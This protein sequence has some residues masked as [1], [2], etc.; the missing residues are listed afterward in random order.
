VSLTWISPQGNAD[1]RSPFYCSA[2]FCL[3]LV[4]LAAGAPARGEQAVATSPNV[5]SEDAAAEQDAPVATLLDEGS[6][7]DLHDDTTV[8]RDV[9]A[10]DD[11]ALVLFDAL[12]LWIGGAAQYDYYNFDG[13]YNH[14][15][16][17]DRDEGS[18]IRRLEGIVRARLF[19]RGELK[20]Q[21]DFDSG[22]VRDAYYRFVS[23]RP[24]TPVTIT[25]G[26]QKEPIGL[27]NL[28]GNKFGMA[29]ERSAPSSVFGNWRSM[30]VRLHKAFQLDAEQRRL[31]IFEEDSS[32]MTTS[33]GVFS[34]DLDDRH[35]T[36]IALTG[37]FTGGVVRGDSGAHLG[38]AASYREGEFDQIRLRPEVQTANKITLA[39]PRA[40]TQ[41]IL[42]VEGALTEGRFYVQAEAF[43]SE[44][45]GRVDGYGGG[46][47]V[48]ASWFLT[49]DRREYNPRWGTL[50]PHKPSGRYSVEIFSRLSHTRGDDD[51]SGWNDYKSFTLG[52]SFFYRKF[53]A[54]V[55]L[56]YGE[57]RE[58]VTNEED[59]VALNLRLQYL[60]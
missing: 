13:I 57:S 54:S 49:P 59:G 1:R 20:L 36:D 29:Q 37:R 14:Q 46:A 18:N 34:S 51:V 15:E 35:D 2:S 32:F 52:A 12:R 48:Q 40:N 47:Y 41:G 4:C 3:I 55:N 30:G 56:L 26:H 5:E 31:D 43:Y 25:V 50:A 28:Y 6:T 45:R 10:L 22:I 19:D 17:G 53:R 8:L 60:L 7:K 11:E 58:P 33:I 42:S 23:N 38:F 21:Y 39:E 9:V 24:N 27:D 16:D 44:Y